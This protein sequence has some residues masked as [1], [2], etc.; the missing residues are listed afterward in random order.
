MAEAFCPRHGPYDAAAGSCPYCG[1]ET[2]AT[3]GP[4]APP[5]LD[6]EETWARAGRSEAV[7]PRRADGGTRR[8][9]RQSDDE[10]PT[11]LGRRGARAGGEE[12]Q[13][14]TSL[15]EEKQGPLGWLIVANGL[16]R[17]H[18]YPIAQGSTIGKSKTGATIVIPDDK[19]SGIHAKLTLEDGHFVL[20]DFGSTNGTFV[21]GKRIREATVLQENDR[22][23]VGTTKLIVKT[24][25]EETEV[26]S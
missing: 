19:V 7:A 21:N 12:P 25:A 6:D 15:M 8:G 23:Q 11:Q 13:E 9:V 20:W 4:S 26:P 14:Q 3:S 18:V 5:P 16:R 24:L 2:R 17:G 22:V 1:K 10:E